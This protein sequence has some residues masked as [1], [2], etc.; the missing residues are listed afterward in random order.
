MAVFIPHVIMD[1]KRKDMLAKQTEFFIL[2]HFLQ[3]GVACV[4]DRVKERMV[5]ILDERQKIGRV[6]DSIN[7]LLYILLKFSVRMLTPY[8]SARSKTGAENS[9]LRA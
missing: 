4:P 8:F 9:L 5:Y 6:I 3:I 2:R 1:V 7:T